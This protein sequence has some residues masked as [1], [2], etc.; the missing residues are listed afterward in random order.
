V[1]RIDGG[2]INLIVLTRPKR[3]LGELNE[4]GGRI[5][6]TV[7]PLVSITA[8]K[9]AFQYPAKVSLQVRC[10]NCQLWSVRVKK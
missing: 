5:V 4:R 7:D 3:D 9:N 1:K 6:S 10:D 8:P 2:G